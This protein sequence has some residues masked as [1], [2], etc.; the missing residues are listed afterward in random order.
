MEKAYELTALVSKLKSRGLD[1]A[2][3][4]AKVVVEEVFDWLS[5]SAVLSENK[6]DD[7]MAPLYP[8]A[9]QAVLEQVDKIDGKV[10]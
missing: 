9:K 8:I 1:I 7:M 10:G 6:Y 2:E 4:S 5:E 3:E